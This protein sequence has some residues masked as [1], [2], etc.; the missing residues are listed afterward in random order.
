MIGQQ[1]QILTDLGIDLWIPRDVA[2]QNFNPAITWRDQSTEQMVE[3]PELTAIPAQPIELKEPVQ[4][5]NVPVVSMPVVEAPIPPTISHD[6]VKPQLEPIIHLANF[7]LQ[8]LDLANCAIVVN[9]TQLSP[10]A[11]Q[12]WVNINQALQAAYQQLNWPFP[13]LNL[14]DSSGAQSYVNGF[15]DAHSVDKQL[16]SLGDVPYPHPKIL[17]LASLDDMLTQPILKKQLWQMI[18]NNKQG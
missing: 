9:A 10:Q 18:Q 15:L 13:L 8:L 7:E 3:L 1:R 2:C 16:I 5:K 6:S 17:K 11:Q 12:L 4:V 14:Q